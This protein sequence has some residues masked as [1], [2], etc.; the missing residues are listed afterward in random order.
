MRADIEH[1]VLHELGAARMV[2]VDEREHLV[3]EVVVGRGVAELDARIDDEDPQRA[4][5]RR[6]GNE[7]EPADGGPG[8]AVASVRSY[9]SAYT[10]T[11]AADL[12]GSWPQKLR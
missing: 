12:R 10:L 11:N 7:Q 1:A 6:P 4:R 3:A 2:G 8:G 9:A 5:P